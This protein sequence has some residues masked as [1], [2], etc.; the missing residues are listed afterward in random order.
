MS[1]AI[2]KLV[3]AYDDLDV[4]ITKY[5]TVSDKGVKSVREHL[6]ANLKGAAMALVHWKHKETLR[7]VLN[8]WKP[9]ESCPDEP[10]RV[11]LSDGKIWWCDSADQVRPVYLEGERK[12][13]A[14][15]HWR[16]I[17]LPAPPAAED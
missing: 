13:P 2:K 4:A 17:E 9:I 12:T 15:T 8:P 5:M 14:V 11:A 7:K 16:N 1:E 3:D 10:R 6:T